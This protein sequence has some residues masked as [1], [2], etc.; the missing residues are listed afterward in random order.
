MYHQQNKWTTAKK[1]EF[2]GQLYDSGF[3]ASYAQ[4]LDL[5]KSAKEIKDWDRQVTLDLRFN[6]YL[7]CT[8]RIDFIVYH[9]DGTTEYVECKGWASPIWRLKWKLFEALYSNQPNVKLTVIR[10]Q[11]NYMLG[12]YKSS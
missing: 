9:H 4:E 3:E 11:S 7:V 12:K 8:Y 1:R 2:K 10:Q 5:R 6:D